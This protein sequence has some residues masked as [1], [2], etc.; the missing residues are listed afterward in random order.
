LARNKDDVER[1]IRVCEKCQKKITQYQTRMPLVITDTPFTV[2][3]KCSIDIVGPFSPSGLQYR[4]M[5]TVEDKLSEFLITKS[6]EDQTSEQEA[7]AFVNHVV[8]IHGVPHFILS[9]CGSQFLS[10]T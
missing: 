4:Y 10:E 8:L 5:L 7:K 6:L 3:E 2:F 9:D 1:Y